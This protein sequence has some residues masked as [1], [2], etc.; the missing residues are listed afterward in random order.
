M[1]NVEIKRA[2][3]KIWT[4]VGTWNAIAA[5]EWIKNFRSAHPGCKLRM[6]NSVA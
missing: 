5:A 4:A 6:R 2:G 3:S 1:W